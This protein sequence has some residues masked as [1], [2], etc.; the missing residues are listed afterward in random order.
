MKDSLGIEKALTLFPDQ[1][2]EAWGQATS[3]D[4]LKITSQKIIISGMGGSSLAGSVFNDYGLPGYVDSSWTLIANSYS[5]NTEETLSAI[6]VA[7]SRGVKIYAVSTGGKIGEMIKSGEIYG[8]ILTPTTNPSNYPKSA[9]GISLGGLLGLMSKAGVIGLSDEEF[10][11]SIEELIEIRKNWDVKSMA[12]KMNQKIPALIAAR[13][14]LGSLH[15]GRNVI[16]EI[17][18]TFASFFDLPELDH[19]LVEATMFPKNLFKDI[20]YLFFVSDLYSERIKTR[21][22][23]TKDL[24]AEQELNFGE[25]KLTGSNSLT[26]AFEIPHYCAWLAFYISELNGEDPGPEPWILKL[27]SE[28]SQPVH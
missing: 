2:K 5:G 16:N 22:K 9:L 18:R 24:F 12:Q 1:L 21:I 28:L 7:K 10:Q 26:Q 20:Y 4:L 27:K 15:A 25:I 13:P 11:K 14:L 17:G 19:H 23:I 6:D 3:N 8:V